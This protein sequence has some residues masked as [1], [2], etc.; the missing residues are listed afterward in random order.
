MIYKVY[1]KKKKRATFKINR[2]KHKK[3]EIATLKICS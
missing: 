3:I 2:V 1:N